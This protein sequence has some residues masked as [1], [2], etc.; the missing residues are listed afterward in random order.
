MCTIP[1][2]QKAS[3]VIIIPLKSKKDLSNPDISFL[4]LPLYDIL[5]FEY[6]AHYDITKIA[7]YFKCSFFA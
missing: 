2:Y 7:S 1:D 4:G 3:N 5:T 6:D